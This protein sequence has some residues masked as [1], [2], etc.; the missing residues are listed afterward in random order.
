VVIP[1]A[2]TTPAND[3]TVYE[4]FD[5]DTLGA[6]GSIARLSVVEQD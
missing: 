5:L 1:V 3:V 6:T 2:L 4:T